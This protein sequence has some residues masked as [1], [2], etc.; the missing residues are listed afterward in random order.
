MAAPAFWLTIIISGAL[1]FLIRL[2][3]FVLLDRWEPPALLKRGLRFVPPAVLTAI[4]FPELLMPGGSLD[5]SLGNTRL[6]AGLAAVLVGWRTRNVFLT[7]AAGMAAFYLLG[8]L[9]H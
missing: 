3:F 6:L 4:I 7:I 2:S 5:V 9:L 8:F 1:T